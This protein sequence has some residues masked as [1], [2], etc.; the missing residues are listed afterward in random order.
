VGAGFAVVFAVAG[1]PPAQA[2]LAGRAANDAQVVGGH[3]HCGEDRVELGE[4]RP[5]PPVEQLR[6]RPGERHRRDHEDR[7]VELRAQLV[8]ELLQV[9]GDLRRRL[10][11]PGHQQP[12]AAPIQ[13][14]ATFRTP[15]T[16][17]RDD[18][19]SF[20]DGWNITT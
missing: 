7:P 16:S 15:P 9:V 1:A 6:D 11:P 17:A 2:Q 14:Y 8:A 10:L 13:P 5:Q 18:P 12:S 19:R 4:V 3:A 20:R